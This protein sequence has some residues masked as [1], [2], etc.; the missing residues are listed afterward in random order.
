MPNY[1]DYLNHVQTLIQKVAQHEAKNIEKAAHLFLEATLRKRNLFVFGASHAGILAHEMVY[2]AGGL[3]TV[4]PVE[5]PSLNLGVRPI[6]HTSQMERLDGY[7]TLIAQTLPLQEGDVVLVHSVSG[8]NTVMI[9]FVREVQS[10]GVSV[11][12]LTN[13]TYSKSVA[14]RHAS[15]KR[16]FELAEVVIDN[17]GALG[18]ASMAFDGLAQKVAPTSTVIGASIVNALLVETVRL[19][20][21]RGIEAP[22]LHSANLDDGDAYNQKLFKTFK[23]NIFY[24]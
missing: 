23:D 14:S 19:C 24:L 5:A 16:L 18:D 20:L 12:A 7:G 6:T 8:R 17:H 21:E 11:I 4:N 15:G 13:V 22:I 3:A 9:D 10:K 2:R 1:L